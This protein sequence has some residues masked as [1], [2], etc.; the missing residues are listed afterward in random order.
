MWHAI[1]LW[2]PYTAGWTRAMNRPPA[3][4]QVLSFSPFYY[5]LIQQ[6]QC[7]PEGG[8]EEDNPRTEQGQIPAGQTSH[9]FKGAQGIR[10]NDGEKQV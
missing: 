7:Y 6:T 8:E 2:M 1:Q 5:L 3:I 4:A 9:C 10:S